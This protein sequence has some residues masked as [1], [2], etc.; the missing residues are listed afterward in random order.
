MSDLT[1]P[2]CAW[3]GCI[4]LAVKK[5]RFG[6]TR[7]EPETITAF[8]ELDLCE[9]HVGE[10]TRLFLIVEASDLRDDENGGSALKHS[11]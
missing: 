3:S 10:V 2:R 8:H 6:G 9:M 4:E 1:G 11:A 7:F 5:V